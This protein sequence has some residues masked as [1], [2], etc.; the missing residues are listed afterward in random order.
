MNPTT[1]VSTCESK[2]IV[3]S[4]LVGGITGSASVPGMIFRPWYNYF[5][6]KKNDSV[7]NS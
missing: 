7:Y 2:A 3:F 5:L 4:S 1:T 6:V